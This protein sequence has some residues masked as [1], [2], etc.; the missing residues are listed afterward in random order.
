MTSA[1]GIS[2]GVEL[3][4]A[5]AGIELGTQLPDP[6]EKR[7]LYFPN[8]LEDYID[9]NSSEFADP[10]ELPQFIL[11]DAGS[12]NDF[13]SEEKKCAAVTQHIA[14]NL[15][16][17]G[18]PAS[19]EQNAK[20]VNFKAWEVGQD[21][22]ID[23]PDEAALFDFECDQD[24][25]FEIYQWHQV[26]VRSPAFYFSSDSLRAIEDVCAVLTSTYCI[27][28]NES[29][30]LHIHVGNGDKQFDFETVRKLAAFIWAFEPQLNSLHPQHRFNEPLFSSMRE[31][32]W[33]H[34]TFSSCFRAANDSKRRFGTSHAMCEP[35]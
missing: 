7:V 13:F 1:S 25:E 15:I 3:E 21:Q 31:K 18:H 20:N 10:E 9:S 23:P 16:K 14:S 8:D 22:S 24:N 35:K 19:L 27:N 11:D 28:V 4:L 29:T 34:T 2:Y 17:A 30:G 33:F 32:R 26:E 6:S 12:D 5:V